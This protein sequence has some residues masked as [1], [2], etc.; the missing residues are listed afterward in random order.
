MSHE[1]AHKKQSIAALTL[2]ALGVVYGDIG[3]SPLYTMRECLGGAHG[4]GVSHDNVLGILSLIF[5]ALIVIISIKYVPFVLRADNRGEGGILALMSLVTFTHKNKHDHFA[6]LLIALGIFGAALLYGDGMITPAITVLGAV[7][8]LS[9]IT[10]FFNPY[11]LPIS[12]AIIFGIFLIQK[13]GTA[14]IGA[15][16]GPLILIWFLTIG[17][18]G[19]WSIIAHPHVLLAI[20]PYYGIRFLLSHGPHGFALLGSVF[21]AVTGGEALYADI[22]HF[23]RIPIR[24]GWFIVA[25]PCLLLNY[26][27]QGAILLVD[28]STI[29]NPFFALAPKALL[30]PMVVLATLAACIASQA[31]ITGAF[32]ITRQAVQLGFLPRLKILHTSSHTIGQIYVPAVNT[33]LMLATFGLVIGFGSSSDLSAAYGVAV[34][35]A[36]LITSAL[37][38]IY[39]RHAW[40][41]PMYKIAL[42]AG[43][44]IVIDITFWASTMMKVPHGGWFP[45]LAGVVLFMIMTT[46]K[47]GRGL[48]YDRLRRRTLSLDNF[49]ASVFEHGSKP[50]RVPG[51]AVFLSGTPNV[52][53]VVLLH[54][55]KYNKV[56][57]EKTVVLSFVFEEISHVPDEERIEVTDL[58]HG[59]YNV[60][61]H[62]GFM[63][64]PH[65]LEIIEKASDKGL[66]FE[67]RTTGFYLGRESIVV[68]KSKGMAR[69]RTNMFAMLSRLATGATSYFGIPP[70]QVVEL[71]VQIEM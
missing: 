43:V 41:W 22:G 33:L 36:M 15:Y 14:R 18:L 34:S 13:W 54:N 17:A 59:F 50:K 38:A 4:A 40:K 44:F 32:S 42:T 56:L 29:A 37:L 1:S 49:V 31:V 55:L 68:G 51:A 9:V 60:I 19:L 65:I 3:T 46:W 30:Y 57:H 64:S 26:F 20:N 63:E 6:N 66:Q 8:G 35:T 52:V 7:E 21:L 58:G 24:N 48:L 5:W 11:I 53:P 10:E 23:G 47:K 67:R 45:L 71:G 69:W 28:E 61:A 62:Y 12:L 2:G 27:G 25:L 39:M 16:F 70:N